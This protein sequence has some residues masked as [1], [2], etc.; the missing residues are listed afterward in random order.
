MALKA[1]ISDLLTV[2]LLLELEI[3]IRYARIF[4]PLGARLRVKQAL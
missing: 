1:T 3:F 2:I 4:V